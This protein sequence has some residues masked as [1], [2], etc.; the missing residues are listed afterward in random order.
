MELRRDSSNNF[1]GSF[2]KSSKPLFPYLMPLQCGYSTYTIEVMRRHVLT[3]V[4]DKP[5]KCTECK[6]SFIQRVQLLKHFEKHRGLTCNLCKKSFNSK[7][8]YVMPI[9]DYL[10]RSY[11]QVYRCVQSLVHTASAAAEAH[12]ETPRTHM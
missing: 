12:R 5:Y 11:V 7:P 8:K 1:C 2:L 9:I 4:Q 3:H 10:L 6:A